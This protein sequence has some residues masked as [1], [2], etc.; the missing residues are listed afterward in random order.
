[1]A[2]K[3]TSGTLEMLLLSILANGDAFSG[4]EIASILA[5]PIPLM[6][7]VKHSQIYPALGGLEKRGDIEGRWIAQNGRP[8]KKDYVLTT[9]GR[10]RLRSWLLEA[11]EELSND[12]IRL[13]AYNL[14]LIGHEP[15]ADAL[16]LYREQSVAAKRQLEDRWIKGTRSSWNERANDDRMTG[17]RSVYEHALAVIDAQIVWSD[18]GLARARR[19][20]ELTHRTEDRTT[21]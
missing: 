5:A 21:S 6:W 20:V 1:M 3:R 18:E 10:E 12:E 15:V 4:Y 13:I 7:P 8:N 9:D 19:A 16:A 17:M 2:A 14:D 11:R